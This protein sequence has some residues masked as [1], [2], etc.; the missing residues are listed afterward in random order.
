MRI[1]VGV[2]TNNPPF[3]Y[4]LFQ[5]QQLSALSCGW[6]MERITFSKDLALHQLTA[7]GWV[8]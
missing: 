4:Q 7:A 8:P 2:L 3:P 6:R 5:L 1:P